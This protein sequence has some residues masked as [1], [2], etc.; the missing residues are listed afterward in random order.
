MYQVNS[1]VQKITADYYRT[2]LK[3]SNWYAVVKATGQYV[4]TL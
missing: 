1:E 2:S 4:Y 3:A